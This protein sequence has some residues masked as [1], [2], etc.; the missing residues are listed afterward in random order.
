M[1][2]HPGC[3]DT[4]AETVTD[5]VRE[6]RER[7]VSELATKADLAA[8]RSDLSALEMRVD[9]RLADLKAELKSDILELKVGMFEIRADLLKWAIGLFLVQGGAV[10]ALLKLLPGG[11]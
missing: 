7:D 3:S 1:F 11:H 9:A 4:K 2:G 5:V 10:V 6:V 8:L